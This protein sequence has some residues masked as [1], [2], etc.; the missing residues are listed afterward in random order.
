MPIDWSLC[1]SRLAP[2]LFYVAF[3]IKRS[4][5]LTD[6]TEGLI[7]IHDQGIVHG[8]LNGVRSFALRFLP[9]QS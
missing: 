2:F 6:I 9:T 4:P 5:Q 7:Y 3:T 8:N 1:V